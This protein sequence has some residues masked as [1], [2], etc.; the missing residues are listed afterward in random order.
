[1][2]HSGIFSIVYVQLSAS[3]VKQM[4]QQEREARL[5]SSGGPTP[6]SPYNGSASAGPPVNNPFLT[7]DDDADDQ[8][9]GFGALS[10]YDAGGQRYSS[11]A[12]GGNSP[13]WSA[14]RPPLQ[15]PQQQ[16]NGLRW[17]DASGPGWSSDGGAGGSLGPGSGAGSCGWGVREEQLGSLHDT[18]QVGAGKAAFA[19]STTLRARRTARNADVFKTVLRTGA[20]AMQYRF[21]STTLVVHVAL[22]KG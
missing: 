14:G 16:L 17:R 1:M 5:S 2:H 18:G 11:S 21:A 8:I 6:A 4:R 20:I 9:G 12:G 7:G 19:Q 13:A 22:P 10:G 3:T 15:Q